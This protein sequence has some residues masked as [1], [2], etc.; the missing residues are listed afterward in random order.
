MISDPAFRVFFIQLVALLMA[1]ASFKTY[2]WVSARK[3]AKR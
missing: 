3:G 1:L 2:M